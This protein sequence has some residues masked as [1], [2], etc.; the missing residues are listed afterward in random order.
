ML[1]GFKRPPDPAS[2]SSAFAST[3]VGCKP[4]KSQIYT[5]AFM[6]VLSKSKSQSYASMGDQ[7]KSFGTRW[8]VIQQAYFNCRWF[9]CR[10]MM[11]AESLKEVHETTIAC[12]N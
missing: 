11:I 4:I 3:G 10:P 7:I 6:R 9:C 5:H 8:I 1:F 2:P 12:E